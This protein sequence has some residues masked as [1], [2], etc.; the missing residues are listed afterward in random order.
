MMTQ[1]THTD[2]LQATAHK[3]LFTLSPV[4]IW[5]G[6]AGTNSS[7]KFPLESLRHTAK[8]ISHYKCSPL[9]WETK[10]RKSLLTLL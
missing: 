9:I 10:Y 4:N 6:E 5:D 2:S 1:I 8:N 3:V 7:L